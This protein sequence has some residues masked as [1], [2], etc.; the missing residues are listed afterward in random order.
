MTAALLPSGLKTMRLDHGFSVFTRHLPTTTY[1]SG[2]SLDALGEAGSGSAGRSRLLALLGVPVDRRGIVL[3][4]GYVAAAAVG[5]IA[6][7][8]PPGDRIGWAYMGL[9][10]MGYFFIQTRGLTVF[11]WLLVAVGGIALVSSGSMSGW[12]QFGIGLALAAVG[13]SAPPNRIESV[14]EEPLAIDSPGPDGHSSTFPEVSFEVENEA[15]ES[16]A[17]TQLAVVAADRL[18]LKALGQLQITSDHGDLAVG[19]EKRPVLSFL[20]KIGRASCRERV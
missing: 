2:I 12:V 1:L 10:L 6:L 20:F 18:V 3:L 15:T 7:L 17:T 4:C 16:E 14:A 5:L 11:L 13:V 19:L 9:A 8:T